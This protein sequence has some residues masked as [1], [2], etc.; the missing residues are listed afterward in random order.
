MTRLVIVRHGNTFEAG[1]PP[2]RIGARTDL[3]LTAAGVAQAEA[4][5]RH[6]AANGIVFDRV[7][8]GAL[9]RTRMT[10]EAIAAGQPIETAAFLTEIDH[11]PDE[12]QSEAA[13]IDRIGNDAITLWETHWGAPEGWEVGAQWRLS[14]WREFVE[15]AAEE[16]PGGTILLVTSNGAARFALA[17]MG[18]KPGEN[19]AG[20]KFRTGSY[21]VLEVG[22]GA[23]FR[24]V[25]WDMRPGETPGDIGLF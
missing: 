15:R 19:R 20:V 22:S 7:L 8:S 2:R 14:A 11:G 13:V 16:L 6:F 5:A 21:G 10:A 24:L 12:G 18:L 23:D 1:E 25:G 4:L 17:A 9:Q 3:P